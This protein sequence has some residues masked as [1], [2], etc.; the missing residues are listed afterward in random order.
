M[1]EQGVDDGEAESG[2]KIESAC[3]SPSSLLLR[4]PFDAMILATPSPVAAKLLQPLDAALAADLG[5]I[6]HSG[7][8]IVSLGY[9]QRIGHP[10]DG[11]GAVVPAV[12]RSPILAVSFSSRKYPHRAPEGKTLLR[13]FVGGARRPDWPP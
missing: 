3:P 5:S 10:L 8:A 4:L 9:D 13:V 12:E 7:T 1:V 11:M 2:E 6:S